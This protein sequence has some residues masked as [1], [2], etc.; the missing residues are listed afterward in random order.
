ML[1]RIRRYFGRRTLAPVVTRLPVWLAKN[2]GAKEHY[3]PGQVKR[4]ASELKLTDTS[5]AIALA[6]CCTA[7]DFQAHFSSADAMAYNRFRDQLTELFDIPVRTFT[8]KH[9]R[10]L[11]AERSSIVSGSPAGDS[12]GGISP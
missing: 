2:F 12:T 3:S 6:A 7:A 1:G 8:C 5:T 10:N 11:S 9:L 4:A